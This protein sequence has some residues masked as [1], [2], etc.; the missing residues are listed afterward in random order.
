MKFNIILRE[1]LNVIVY[2][3]VKAFVTMADL[4]NANAKSLA[5]E[6]R[7]GKSIVFCCYVV[8]NQYDFMSNLLSVPVHS[9]CN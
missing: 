9:F 4:V 8:G 2:I 5:F 1:V 7:K 6:Q 3:H